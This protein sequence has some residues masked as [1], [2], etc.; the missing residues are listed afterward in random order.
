MGALLKLAIGF[1]TGGI[2]SLF[3]TIV[4]WIL[5][6]WKLAL[7]VILIAA[8]GI[9]YKVIITE[10]NVARATVLADAQTIKTLGNQ[11]TAL[12]AAQKLLEQQIATQNDS[13]EGM[14][15]DSDAAKQRAKDAMSAAVAQAKKDVATITALTK[16]AADPTNKGTCDAELSRIR[17]GL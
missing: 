1:C 9:T 10:R 4:P 16:R 14:K 12:Q 13:I 7:G 17:A 2:S 11:V 5:K 6:H 3:T 15:K 8:A